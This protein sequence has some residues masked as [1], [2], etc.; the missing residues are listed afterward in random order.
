MKNLLT[1][2]KGVGLITSACFIAVLA[3]KIVVTFTKFVWNLW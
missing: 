1:F 2:L 3:A